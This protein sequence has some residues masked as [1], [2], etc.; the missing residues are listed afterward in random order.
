MLYG[1]A[2]YTNGTTYLGSE[3]SY[4]CVHN[5]RLS[6]VQ[7]RYCLDNKQWSDATPKCEGKLFYFIKFF[8]INAHFKMPFRNTLSRT[9]I[10]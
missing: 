10:S 2:E 8:L 6:G 4:S 9:N 3:I 1:S 7:K 5:Y